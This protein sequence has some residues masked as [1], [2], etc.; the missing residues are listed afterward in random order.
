[1]ST[2]PDE[3]AIDGKLA[4]KGK[5][6]SASDADDSECEKVIVLDKPES[7]MNEDELQRLEAK[8]AYSKCST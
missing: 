3:R 6:V 7:E 8:R 2:N 1:M 5:P 4:V